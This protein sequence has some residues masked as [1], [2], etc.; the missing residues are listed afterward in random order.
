MR[1][2][3]RVIIGESEIPQ[4]VKPVMQKKCKKNKRRFEGYW[5]HN[6]SGS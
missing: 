5:L 3:H 2:E 6:V 4:T 1:I